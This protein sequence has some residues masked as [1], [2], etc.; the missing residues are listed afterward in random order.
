MHYILRELTFLLALIQIPLF[1]WYTW[2]SVGSQYFFILF[3][4]RHL[5]C[6]FMRHIHMVDIYIGS[7]NA[8]A[9]RLHNIS[10]GTSNWLSPHP[11]P[12]RLT[13]LMCP[14]SVKL[15]KISI[16]SFHFHVWREDYSLHMYMFPYLEVKVVSVKKHT[17]V[18]VH[19]YMV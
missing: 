7:T 5:D 4:P 10:L 13:T 1:A 8:D 3:Y 9:D 16:S 14:P 15:I 17:Y 11:P 12:S 19:T 6:L 18:V 2:I